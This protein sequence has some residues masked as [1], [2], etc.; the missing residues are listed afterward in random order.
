MRTG[1]P[2][3]VQ[4]LVVLGRS[5]Q[6]SCPRGDLNTVA[7]KSSRIGGQLCHHTRLIN[8]SRGVHVARSGRRSPATGSSRRVAAP[9]VAARATT[10]TPNQRPR[11]SQPSVW[12]STPV[13]SSRHSCHRSSGCTIPTRAASRGR[14]AASRRAAIRISA[15]VRTLTTTAWAQAALD[16]HRGARPSSEARGVAL[17]TATPVGQPCAIAHS[18]KLSAR[19]RSWR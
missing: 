8:A 10:T 9:P 12:T 16:D 6:Y 7:V 3:R 4:V 15:G 11:I 13:S 17:Q 18:A 2:A 19:N 5:H 1:R 14:A